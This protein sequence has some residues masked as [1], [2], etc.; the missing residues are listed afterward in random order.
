M[1]VSKFFSGVFALLGTVVMVAAVMVAL[2]NRNAQPRMM[3]SQKEASAQTQKLMN[4]LCA[5]D[6]ET[7][8]SLMY[9]Q[10]VLDVK[11]PEDEASALLWSAYRDSF[12]CGYDGLCY[13]TDTGIVRDITVTV[14]DMD[15]VMENLPQRAK[16]IMDTRVRELEDAQTKAIADAKAAARAASENGGDPVEI[17]EPTEVDREA[18]AEEAVVQAVRDALDEDARTITRDVTLNVI[19]EDGQWW[20]VPDQTLLQMISGVQ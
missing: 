19:N 10:P 3:D 13:V 18:V 16:T 1:K 17:P 2:L 12:L 20:V 9:G 14:L 6:Y 7:A 8:G 4:A 5:G 11:E 15:S